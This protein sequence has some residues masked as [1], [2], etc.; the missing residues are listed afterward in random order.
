MDTDSSL[1]KTTSHV[2]AESWNMGKKMFDTAG[3]LHARQTK[4]A[5]TAAVSS[6][7]PLLC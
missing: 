3:P 4:Q 1:T 6:S 5:A 7:K 2:L